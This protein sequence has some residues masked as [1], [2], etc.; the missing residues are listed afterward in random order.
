MLIYFPV[1][2]YLLAQLVWFEVALPAFEIF[3]LNICKSQVN[4]W[5]RVSDTVTISYFK[6]SVNSADY[7]SALPDLVL[8][9]FKNICE[10]GHAVQLKRVKGDY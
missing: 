9:V 6:H 1:K 7:N 5:F 8:L 3:N 10:M 2:Q 4:F